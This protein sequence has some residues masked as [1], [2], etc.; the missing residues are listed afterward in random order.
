MQNKRWFSLS[1]ILLTFYSFSLA[2][3]PSSATIVSEIDGFKMVM[4][5]NCV[6]DTVIIQTPLSEDPFLYAL[7]R[8]MRPNVKVIAVVPSQKTADQLNRNLNWKKRIHYVITDIK[9]LSKWGRDPF[10]VLYNKLTS[11]Y[12][13]IPCILKP[14]IR[15]LRTDTHIHKWLFDQVADI[16]NLTQTSVDLPSSWAIDGGGVTADRKYVYVGEWSIQKSQ[17]DEYDNEI[18]SRDNVLS[19]IEKI[20]GKKPFV[21]PA[22]DLHS[23]RYHM[24]IGK[25]KTGERVNFLADPVKFLEL[26]SSLTAEE[27]EEAIKSMRQLGFAY[28][29]KDFLASELGKMEMDRLNRRLNHETLMAFL[30]TST[31]T[32][33]DI[34]TSLHVQWLQKAEERLKANGITVVRI[35]NLNRVIQV[36]NFKDH[37]AKTVEFPLGFYYVNL[38]QDR[39]N[40]QRTVIIPKYGIKKIDDYVYGQL[41]NLGCF[42]KIIQIPSVIEGTQ[43]GGPR[44]R[45][46]IL[47]MPAPADSK[48]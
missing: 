25:T 32:I 3:T 19:A 39:M 17:R 41:K 44:C 20:S 36:E 14:K 12:T 5:S 18:A 21:L 46:Q 26:L 34:K 35:P 1:A 23:D 33:Q 2:N 45:V 9:G 30:N 4:D 40:G 24:P 47:G 43:A 48:N 7:L 28:K 6:W 22:T 8:I 38:L 13:L 10:T 29:D 11:Q 15:A 42:K 31:D 16:A 37:S 27:K